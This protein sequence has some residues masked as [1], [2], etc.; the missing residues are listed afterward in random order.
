[1]SLS[2][3][4]GRCPGRTLDVDVFVA[5]LT[6]TVPSLEILTSSKSTQPVSDLI[7]SC[8]DWQIGG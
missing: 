4:S 1:M 6:V 2:N 5:Q 3:L 7:E 8:G